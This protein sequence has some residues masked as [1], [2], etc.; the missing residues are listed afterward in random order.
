MKPHLLALM[1]IVG[2]AGAA[3]AQSTAPTPTPA[4]AALPAGHV[5]D[6]ATVFKKCAAC[7]QVGPTAKNAV[8]PALNGIVGRPAG[9]YPGYNYSDANK[10]SGLVWTEQTLADYLPAPVANLPGTKMS[11]AGLKDAQDVADVIAYLKTF[12]AQGRPAQ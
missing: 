3:I 1:G 8:G 6:G 5:E 4:G 7:H 9:T 10:K 12:D 2:L 11:F